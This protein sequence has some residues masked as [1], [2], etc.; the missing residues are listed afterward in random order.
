MTGMS[1]QPPQDPAQPP[2]NPYDPHGAPGYG[3]PGY[4][5]PGY[6][7]TGV[8][9]WAPDHPDSTMVLLLGILGMAVCQVI[10]PFA[11]VKG[12]RVKREIDESGGR[13]GGRSQVQVGYV[14]GIVGSVILGLYVVGFLL[15]LVVVVIALSTGA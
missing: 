13:Y 2:Q 7:A 10:A 3:A 4:G 8:P 12:A 9:Y 15:Y 6:G 1:E 5:A 14:L 11:W